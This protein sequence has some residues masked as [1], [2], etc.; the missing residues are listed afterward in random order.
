MLEILSLVKYWRFWALL[1]GGAAIVGS[2]WYG[3]H[4]YDSMKATIVQDAQTI[5]TLGEANA[6]QKQVL[7]DCSNA[8]AALAASSASWEFQARA[9][10]SLANTKSQTYTNKAVAILA[11][12]A[13]AG[14]SDYD[15]TVQLFNEAISELKK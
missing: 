5:K 9:A 7:Q 3:V 6:Q 13:P 10:Q 15:A 2:I 14:V 4:H 8:T 1:A 12:K 11:K